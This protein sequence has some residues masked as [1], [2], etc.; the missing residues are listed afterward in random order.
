[1]T[2]TPYALSVPTRTRTPSR[3]GPARRPPVGDPS[4]RSRSEANA[5]LIEVAGDAWDQDP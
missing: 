4:G 5:V 3:S 2:N 1:M